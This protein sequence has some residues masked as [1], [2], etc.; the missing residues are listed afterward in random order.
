MSEQNLEIARRAIAAW[1]AGEM[2][3]L[4]ALYDPDAV[5]RY[6]SDWLG[7]PWMGRDAI[8]DQ[9]R[10]LREVWLDDSTFGSPEMLDAGDHVV[11]EIP[12][13]GETRG[14]PLVTEVTWV[15]TMRDGSIVGVEF[16]RSRDEALE[17]AERRE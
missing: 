15:Y 13:H 11:V 7:G 9:F 6:P 10:D 14:L 12:F 17:A 4:R 2:A 5:M 1:N 16:F 8:M 3:E